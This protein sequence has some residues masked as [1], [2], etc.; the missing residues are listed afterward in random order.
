MQIRAPEAP[1][2]ARRIRRPPLE[3]GAPKCC[4]F[5]ATERADWPAGRVGTATSWAGFWGDR[6][7][8]D[9]MAK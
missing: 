6:A 8:F 9:Q 4:G 1:C 3:S 5:R 2:D 7:D